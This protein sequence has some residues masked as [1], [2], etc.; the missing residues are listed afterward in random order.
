MERCCV[1]ARIARTTTKNNCA[2]VYL[3]EMDFLAEFVR[4]LF[5]VK[6]DFIGTIFQFVKY[7][8]HSNK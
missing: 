7:Y 4:D 3:I 2:K 8:H 5:A 6:T 1:R